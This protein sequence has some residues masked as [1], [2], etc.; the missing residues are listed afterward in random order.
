MEFGRYINLQL[1]GRGRSGKIRQICK[2]HVLEVAFSNARAGSSNNES[3]PK[4]SFVATDVRAQGAAKAAM[5]KHIASINTKSSIPKQISPATVQGQGNSKTLRPV[6]AGPSGRPQ[7]TDR[8][9]RMTCSHLSSRTV[10]LGLLAR[11]VA[12]QPPTPS[13]WSAQGPSRK[14]QG[15][16][17]WRQR[18]S[19]S[20]VVGV[21]VARQA[22]QGDE[23]LAVPG[24]F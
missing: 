7:R 23:Q 6:H 10:R 14:M 19:T 16:R 8:F 11:I 4:H 5:A 9:E 13:V 18:L 21:L 1:S 15:W 3:R 2:I 22:Q 12:P 20:F 24:C 17:A